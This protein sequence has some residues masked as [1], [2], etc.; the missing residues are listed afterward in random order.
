VVGPA[1]TS[2]REI[3]PCARN[4]A[5]REISVDG[6]KREWSAAPAAA[7]AA[8]N[9]MVATAARINFVVVFM[10]FL[11]NRV[12]AMR[13]GYAVHGLWVCERLHE[14]RRRDA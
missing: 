4:G 9:D 2:P 11:L 7:G 1:I 14:A 10:G 3:E 5:V 12:I 8:S 6:G 13:S